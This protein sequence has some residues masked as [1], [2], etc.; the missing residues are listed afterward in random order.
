MNQAQTLLASRDL[1]F[2]INMLVK[3]NAPFD[4]FLKDNDAKRVRADRKVQEERRAR[5]QKEHEKLHLLDEL[6]CSC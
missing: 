1:N 4:K 3:A 6:F 2:L 5:D